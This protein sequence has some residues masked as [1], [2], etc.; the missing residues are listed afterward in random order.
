MRRGDDQEADETAPGTPWVACD[1]GHRRRLADPPQPL[2]VR[3]PVPCGLRGGAAPNDR[4]GELDRH[5]RYPQRSTDEGRAQDRGLAAKLVR[6]CA[7]V[8]RGVLFCGLAQVWADP[9]SNLP[10][11]VVP[12]PSTNLGDQR[13]ALMHFASSPFRPRMASVGVARGS[14]QGGP[15]ERPTRKKAGWSCIQPPETDRHRRSRATLITQRSQVQILPPQPQILLVDQ[16]LTKP[17]VTR[18]SAFLGLCAHPVPI[19][20]PSCAQPGTGLAPARRLAQ[21]GPP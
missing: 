14:R 1:A 8:I 4:R 5:L 9:C 3:E 20:C 19:S 2:A 10:A 15:C 18:A 12:I 11:P 13:S 16:A 6:N 17:A 7:W 21:P